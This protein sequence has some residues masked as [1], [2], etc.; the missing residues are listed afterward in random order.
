MDLPVVPHPARTSEWSA[1]YREHFAVVWSALVRLGVPRSDLEDAVQDVFLVAHRRRSA[2][3]GESSLRTWL[4]GIS[5]RVAADHRRRSRRHRRRVEA[6]G[7]EPMPPIQPDETLRHA[8]GAQHLQ[9]FLD[10]LDDA[11]REVF[12]LV[13]LQELTGREAAQVLALNRN[14]AVARLRAARQAF[15]RYA[16]RCG[17]PPKRMLAAAHRQAQPDAR[18]RSRVMALV[19]GRQGTPSSIMATTGTA[20]LGAGTTLKAVAISI[21]IAAAGLGAIATSTAASRSSTTVAAGRDSAEST[22]RTLGPNPRPTSSATR[23]SNSSAPTR[24]PNARPAIPTTPTQSPSPR[25]PATATTTSP[26]PSPFTTTT[27]TT[28]PA[29]APSTTAADPSV[30]SASGRPSTSPSSAAP[31]SAGSPP[32]T[33]IDPLVMDAKALRRARAALRDGEPTQALSIARD[34]L[35][36]H[37]DGA[38]VRELAVVQVEALCAQGR[39]E[40]ARTE[41]RQLERRYPGSPVVAQARCPE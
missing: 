5:R 36:A 31:S 10:S 25:P 19:M 39:G 18:T 9:R 3:S 1:A 41:L 40:Q 24:S 26:A 28:V 15:D 37:P 11:K 7:R 6:I 34:V 20:G 14:T 8:R 4:L 27:T 29:P 32:T 17:R 13:E 38:L 2:F 35:R 21:A 22:T 33:R 30:A 12:V 16:S 23:F